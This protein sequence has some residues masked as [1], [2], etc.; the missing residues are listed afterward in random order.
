M[1]NRSNPDLI[2]YKTMCLTDISKGVDEREVVASPSPEPFKT[3]PDTHLTAK[4]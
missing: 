1:E 3:R 2:L 4:V